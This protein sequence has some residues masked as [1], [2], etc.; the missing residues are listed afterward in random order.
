MINIT[1]ECRVWGMQLPIAEND[2]IRVTDHQRYE[3]AVLDGT[4]LRQLLEH[5]LA[6]VALQQALATEVQR[7]VATPYRRQLVRAVLARETKEMRAVQ[8]RS[9]KRKDEAS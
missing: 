3:I 1:H 4:F 2:T 7:P 8:R 6:G 5:H 9:R